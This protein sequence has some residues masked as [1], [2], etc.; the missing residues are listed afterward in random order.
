MHPMLGYYAN[1]PRLGA[2]GDFLTAP[3]ASQMFGELLGLWAADCWQAM[4]APTRFELIEL[5]PGRGT[6]MAN[7][8]RATAKV[9]GFHAAAHVSLIE[10]SPVLAAQQRELLAVVG[11]STTHHKDLAAVPPGPCLI[12]ANEV[13]DCLPIRQF[14]RVGPRWHERLVGATSDQAGLRF[15][16]S[17]DPVPPPADLPPSLLDA[18]EG[19]VAEIAPALP[20]FTEGLGARL[21]QAP[22]RALI[23]DYT[24]PPGGDSLQAVAGHAKVDPLAAPG[25]ADLTAHVDFQRLV[26]L[27]QE[28]GLTVQGPTSQGAFLQTL[29]IDQRAQA[30]ASANPSLAAVVARQHQRLTAATEMGSL[31]QVVCFSSPPLPP[32]AGFP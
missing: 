20:S 9:P 17:P 21:R 31:F 27:A 12:L 28:E 30:L 18:P 2:E 23:I 25:T 5:G 1:R 3:E 15:G 29:G 26:R 16:L 13:L 32:A 19:T 10:P 7:A 22:G 4:G 6:L 14:V 8:W 11:L 24:S